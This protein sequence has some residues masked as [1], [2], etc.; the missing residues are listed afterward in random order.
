MKHRIGISINNLQAIYGDFRALEIA[1]EVGAD[2]VDFMT[3]RNSVAKPDS[4][5]AKSDEEITAYFKEVKRHADEVGIEIAQTHGRLRIYLADPEKDVYCLENARRD[6]LA[7]AALEVPCCVMHSVTT[8]EMGAG[9]DKQVMRDLCFERFNTIIG[10][11]KEYGV[12]IATETFGYCTKLEC[13]EQFADF[14]EFKGIYDRIASH[15]D[16]ADWFKICVDTGH[17][18]ASVRFDNPS[19]GDVIRKLGKDIVCLHM[20]D[21]DGIYDQH[22]PIMTGTIDWEDVFCALDEIGYD[23]VYNMEVKLPYFGKGFEKETAEFSV[24]LLRFL[25]SSRTAK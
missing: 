23:G 8:S 17:S 21:N 18:H 3:D 15:G 20:H 22:K 2:A 4:I 13:L 16:N 6:L 24:K 5:Y 1:K 11:A 10:W 12:K 9:A 19:V 14:G 7:A 25:L